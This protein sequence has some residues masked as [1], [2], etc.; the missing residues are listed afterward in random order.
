MLLVFLYK[1][2]IA[3][4]VTATGAAA[5][6]RALLRKAW[7]VLRGHTPGVSART[8]VVIQFGTVGHRVNPTA[9]RACFSMVQEGDA[10]RRY[11]LR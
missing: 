9:L 6:E 7:K 8:W 10:D 1:W 5:S 11:F 3:A 2:A 4:P